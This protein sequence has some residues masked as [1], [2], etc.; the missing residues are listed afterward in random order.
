MVCCNYGILIIN[1]LAKWVESPLANKNIC[2]SNF[3]NF[4]FSRDKMPPCEL[5]IVFNRFSLWGL[6]EISTRILDDWK[7]QSA[8]VNMIFSILSLSLGLLFYKTRRFCHECIILVKC[9]LFCG[10]FKKT[11]IKTLRYKR[12]LR[13]YGL[14]LL[15]FFIK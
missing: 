4:P 7:L 10:I 13:F 3:E 11:V 6:T 12:V 14:I 15:L 8:F 5:H 2:S 9:C 1:M